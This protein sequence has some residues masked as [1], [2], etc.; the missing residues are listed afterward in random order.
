MKLTL[1]K[2]QQVPVFAW[3]LIL[4]T[5]FSFT[6]VN[7]YPSVSVCASNKNDANSILA[8]KKN[9]FMLLEFKKLINGEHIILVDNVL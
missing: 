6:T 2:L 9:L 8:T 1:A 5:G 7:S 4:V 3:F